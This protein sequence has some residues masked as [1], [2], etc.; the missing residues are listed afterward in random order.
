MAISERFLRTHKTSDLK[1]TESSYILYSG[2]LAWSY[3]FVNYYLAGL[4]FGASDSARKLKFISMNNIPYS[5][6]ISRGN[7]F[8]VEPDF[9]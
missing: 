3:I 8:E 6:N 4:Y 7:I 2:F 9:L 5:L 1:S